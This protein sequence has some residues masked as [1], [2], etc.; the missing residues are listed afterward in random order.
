MIHLCM[1]HQLIAVHCL[2]LKNKVTSLVSQNHQKYLSN[3]AIGITIDEK[4]FNLLYGNFYSD[5][6][7]SKEYYTGYMNS[8]TGSGYVLDL[9]GIHVS[10]FW[11]WS[12]C[13][14]YKHIDV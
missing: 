3:H 1:L 7:H 9:L 14:S 5:V 11:F 13:A 10:C 6:V 8:L 2:N 4:S 12:G